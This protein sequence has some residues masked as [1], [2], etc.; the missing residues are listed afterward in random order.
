MLIGR[1]T[2]V[3]GKWVMG[4]EQSGIL[5]MIK[6]A[7]AAV[8]AT[9]LVGSVAHAADLIV[10]EAAPVYDAV[11]T[12]DW[13]GPYLGASIGYGRG[14]VEWNGITTDSYDISGWLAGIQGGYNVQMDNLVVGVEGAIDWSGITGD[15]NGVTRDIDWQGSLTGK[16][17]FAV[18]SLL[19]YGKAGVAFASSTATL[20]GNTDSQTHTGWTA[21]LGVAA[22]VN[23]SMSIFAEYN[24]ADYAEQE[25]DYGFTTPETAFTTSAVK[26]GLNWHF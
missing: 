8:A 15:Y 14:T 19:F 18:D 24:Y 6:L 1:L 16:L 10:D 20:F 17:G 13:T 9:L 12:G 2:H 26:V 25:Y 5:E 21:G 7:A 4:F 22:K 3:S 23:D 11:A